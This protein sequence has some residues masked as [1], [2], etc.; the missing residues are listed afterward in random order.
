MTA[1]LPGYGRVDTVLCDIDGVVVLGKD[2][3]PGAGKALQ[4]MHDAGIRVLFVTNNS[5]KTRA[6]IAKVLRDTVGFDPGADA[7]VNSGVAT[8][9]FLA[10]KVEAVY[11]LGTDGLRESLRDSG[12]NVVEDW[13]EA[14][15]VV[16]GL[17]FNLSYAS[18]V[19]ATLAV[20]HGATFY[21][22]N[23][24]STYPTAEGLYPG[25]GSISAVVERAT[26]LTPI[27]CGKPYEPMR[28]LLE[29]YAGDHPLIVGDRAD[30]D[31]ALGKAEG[32]ATALVM[33]GVTTDV[34]DIPH[35]YQ[36]DIVLES[37]AE[38]P[39]ALGLS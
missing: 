38:L 5:T 1:V 11:V 37:L 2:P 10:G 13:H 8:G 26:G 24:D 15:A 16:T 9:Q 36:P 39:A 27:V 28:T 32:W 17:D 29:Q 20:Q 14:D 31:I 12:V 33:T 34:G 4:T 30:T 19:G 7:V 23:D 3:V 6:T 18:L 25:A 21:A 35:R 22:T